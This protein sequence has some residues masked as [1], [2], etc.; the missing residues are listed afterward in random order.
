MT[1]KIFIKKGKRHIQDEVSNQSPQKAKRKTII[2]KR[3]N[4]NKKK[5]TKVVHKE[6][7]PEK[8]WKML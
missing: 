8:W 7:L 5:Q 4:A 6:I 3:I 2:N 1:C